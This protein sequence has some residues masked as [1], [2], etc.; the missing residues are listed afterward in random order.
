VV[1]AEEAISLDEFDEAVRSF[2]KALQMACVA[3]PTDAIDII[4]LF[5]K[6]WRAVKADSPRKK[7][8]PLI[9]LGNALLGNV[10]LNT[11]NIPI[12]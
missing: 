12:E 1:P 6:K 9:Q 3:L 10:A 7:S 5:K 8:R 11:L 4:N 2:L